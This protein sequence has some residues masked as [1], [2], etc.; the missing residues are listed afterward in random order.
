MKYPRTRK[1]NFNNIY[2]YVH[3]LQ[4]PSHVHAFDDAKLKLQNPFDDVNGIVQNPMNMLTQHC[5]LY[6]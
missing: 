6:L 3:I 5:V 4:F 2:L 1:L